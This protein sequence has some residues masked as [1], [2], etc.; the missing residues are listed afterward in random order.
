M[1][2][3]LSKCYRAKVV[4]NNYKNSGGIAAP[5]AVK[6]DVPDWNAE[7]GKKATVWAYPLNA[8]FVGS[9]TGKVK[10]S[11][12]CIIPPVGCD[13]WVAWEDSVKDS[14]G[15]P[16]DNGGIAWYFGS[17]GLKNQQTIPNENRTSGNPQEVYTVL[18]TPRGRTIVMSDENGSSKI[19]IKGRG[20]AT[21]P[22]VEGNNMAITLDESKTNQIVV[23]SGNGLQT[24]VVNKD[25]NTTT[26]TQGN[27]KI[28]MD[29]SNIKIT[30]SGNIT[31]KAS[32]IDLN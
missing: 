30:T 11:G 5:G 29:N 21:G 20:S 8:F 16:L 4:D 15:N 3:D 24:I 32:R 6:V 12:Q 27:S 1:A 31:L 26:I 9:D 23:Q 17:V 25:A 18:Q 2:L 14:N 19:V 22:L 7:S 13:V 28:F 10:N